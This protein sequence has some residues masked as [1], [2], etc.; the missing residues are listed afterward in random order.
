M[1]VFHYLLMPL[2][3]LRQNRLVYNRTARIRLAVFD[4]SDKQDF[5]AL[6]WLS[7]K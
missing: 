4:T 1:R 3:Q 6:V 2:W 7:L 5:W